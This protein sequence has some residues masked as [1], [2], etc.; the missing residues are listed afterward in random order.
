MIM[1][2]FCNTVVKSNF[3]RIVLILQVQFFRSYTPTTPKN[4]KS[5]N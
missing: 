2:T 5:K 4:F 3:N 1:Y